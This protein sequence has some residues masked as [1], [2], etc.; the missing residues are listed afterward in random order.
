M[1]RVPLTVQ[2]LTPGGYLL[3]TDAAGAG[4]ELH[5]DGNRR[6]PMALQSVRGHLGIK[7]MSAQWRLLTYC[8]GRHLPCVMHCRID[9]HVVVQCMPASSSAL[10]SRL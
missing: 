1:R 7:I 5:P 3:A 4:F 9:C 8:T 6:A 2:G 10:S